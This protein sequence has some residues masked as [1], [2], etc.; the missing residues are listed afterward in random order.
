MN[1][2]IP[3][4]RIMTIQNLK[5]K[6]FDT[7]FYTPDSSVIKLNLGKLNLNNLNKNSIKCL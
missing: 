4:I 5:G 1:L 7:I 3:L 2:L 6:R